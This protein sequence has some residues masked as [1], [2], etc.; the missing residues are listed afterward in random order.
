MAGNPPGDP[1]GQAKNPEF[2]NR[3]EMVQMVPND[4]KWSQKLQKN[5]LGANQCGFHVGPSLKHVE[6]IV[7]HVLEMNVNYRAVK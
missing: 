7:E 1:P 6:V 5:V 3:S 4:A 2:E